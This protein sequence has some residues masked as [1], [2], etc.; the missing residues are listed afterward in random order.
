MVNLEG[1]GVDKKLGIYEGEV[2]GITLEVADRTKLGGD[3]GLGTVLSGRFLRVRG[4]ATLR[5]GV[6]SLRT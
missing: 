2:P 6:K 4:T 1:T 5:I 3:K